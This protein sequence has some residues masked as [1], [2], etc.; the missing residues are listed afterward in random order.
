MARTRRLRVALGVTIAFA[1]LGGRDLPASKGLGQAELDLELNG[2]KLFE[3]ETFGGNGRTCQTCHSKHTGTIGL[4]D[5]QQIIDKGDPE[6]LLVGDA[7][8]DDG[9]GTTRVQA[10]ATIAITLKLPPW[11]TMADDPGATHVTVF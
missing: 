4:A 10:N 8:D 5:V 1:T 7:L 11:V 9:V 3:K 6:S 2:K